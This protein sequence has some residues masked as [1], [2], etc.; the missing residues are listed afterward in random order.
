MNSSDFP[1]GCRV[2]H[3]VKGGYSTL[4][5]GKRYNHPDR[6]HEAEVLENKS[7]FLLIR[8]DNGDTKRV[9]PNSLKIKE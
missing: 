6:F 2:I 7:K 3:I 8:F 5:G 1:I 9:N 4:S